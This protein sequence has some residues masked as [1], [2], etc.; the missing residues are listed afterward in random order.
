MRKTFRVAGA[1]WFASLLAGSSALIA[2]EFGASVYL[3]VLLLGWLLT[4]GLPTLAAV[5]MLASVW[6]GP[7]LGMF[8]VVAAV[9]AFGAQFAA[10]WTVRRLLARRRAA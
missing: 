8:V 4:V 3:H 1:L 6:P 9:L 7:S 2:A 5:V 10:V